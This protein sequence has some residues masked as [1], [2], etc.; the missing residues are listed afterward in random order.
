MNIIKELTSIMKRKK[1]FKPQIENSTA[2]ILPNRQLTI[3]EVLALPEDL[4]WAWAE[5]D[6]PGD[7]E[8]M[9]STPEQDEALVRKAMHYAKRK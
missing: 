9:E 4:F 3:E 2:T 7:Y 5:S 1:T 8:I 6:Q